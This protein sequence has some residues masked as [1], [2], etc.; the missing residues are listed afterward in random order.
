MSLMFPPKTVKFAFGGHDQITISEIAYRPLSCNEVGYTFVR[1]DGTGVAEQFTHQKLNSLV[2]RGK[3]R[4]ERN[5][6]LPEE[7]VRRWGPDSSVIALQTDKQLEWSRE[8]SAFIEA[9]LELERDGEIKRTDASIEQNNGKLVQRARKF[10]AKPGEKENR[11]KA[12]K[13]IAMA[14]EVRPRTLRR[15]LAAYTRSGLEALIDGRVASGRRAGMI[16]CCAEGEAILYTEVRKYLSPSEPTQTQIWENVRDAFAAE[17]EKRAAENERQG[18]EIRTLLKV[19]SQSAVRKAIL[20]LDPYLVTLARKGETAA[21]NRFRPV[22][23]GLAVLRPLE[24]VE[25]D[26]C[27]IDLFSILSIAGIHDVF[28]KEDLARLGLDDTSERWW[29]SIAICTA[30]RCIVAMKLSRAPSTRCSI[31]TL[32]MIMTDKGAW[33]DAAGSTDHWWM[34]GRPSHI[35]TDCGS[36]FLSYEFRAACAALGITCERAPAGMPEF[37]AENERW[38]RTLAL[39]LLPRL[40]GYARSN[41]IERGDKEPQKEAALTLDELSKVLV[42]WVVDAYH[43]TPHAGLDGRRP[44]EVWTERVA[45]W[46]VAPLP[47]LRTRR[48]VFGTPLSRTVSRTGLLVMGVRYHSEKLARW[49]LRNG[50]QAVPVRWYPTDIGAIEVHLDKEWVTVPAVVEDLDGVHAQ[51]WLATVRRMRAHSNSQFEANLPTI[52]KALDDIRAINDEAMRQ[53]GIA[54]MDW[55]EDAVEAEEDR[56]FIG[57][58]LKETEE[59]CTTAF[60]DGLGRCMPTACAAGPVGADDGVEP[61]GGTV[62]TGEGPRPGARSGGRRARSWN[63][64]G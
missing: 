4:H 21:R 12:G 11:T 38:F 10:M 45:E 52:R 60:D 37:R 7:A 56:L 29:L 23:Q 1:V 32:E 6:F 35:V 48:L 15:W 59:P 8:R 13:R 47:D 57:F 28:S 44:A 54:V 46:G 27:K 43:N 9:F 25:M 53:A 50:E 20:R 33:S 17:N 63:V 3:L 41:I 51:T 30:T 62:S 58:S 18:A 16:C 36:H 64:R 61:D 49:M 2:A 24:R 40:S 31:E 55:S 22:G 39:G 34:A 42:R 19:P 5:K 26:E 14:A